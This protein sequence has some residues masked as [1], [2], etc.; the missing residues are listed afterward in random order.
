VHCSESP[1]E[2]AR[3]I[4]VWFKPAELLDYKTIQE[5]ILYDVNLDGILE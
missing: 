2:A 3:E 4:A 1:E 5:R